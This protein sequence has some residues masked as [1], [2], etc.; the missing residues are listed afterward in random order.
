MNFSV[1]ETITERGVNHS[2]GLIVSIRGVCPFSETICDNSAQ[3][4]A[5]SN[6]FKWITLISPRAV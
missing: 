5:Y 3:W 6:S 4:K 2:D 1:S